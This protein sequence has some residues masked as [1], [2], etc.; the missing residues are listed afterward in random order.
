M[1]NKINEI[2]VSDPLG[3]NWRKIYFTPP[4]RG[5]NPC[6][7]CAGRGLIENGVQNYGH[8]RYVCPECKG[9]G[10]RKHNI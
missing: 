7:C 9:T 3:Y 5:T 4:E 1:K 2:Y 10:K 6:R 8:V